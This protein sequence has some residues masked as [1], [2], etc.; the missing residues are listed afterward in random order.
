MSVN[1]LAGDPPAALLA[2]K[3]PEDPPARPAPRPPVI[4][5]SESYLGKGT[6][7][8]DYSNVNSNMIDLKNKGRK[9]K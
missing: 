9:G 1:N 6:D 7:I 5:D 3:L 2:T 4:E 8:T